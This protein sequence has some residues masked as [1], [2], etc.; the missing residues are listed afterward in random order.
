L[1]LTLHASGQQ[2][3]LAPGDFTTWLPISD[4]EREMKA[5]IVEKEAGAEVLLWRVHVVDELLGNNSELQRVFYHYIRLK[6]FDEKGKE[7]TSTIDLPYVAPGAILAVSGRTIKADGTV[8]ELDRKSVYRRDVVRAGGSARKAVSFAMPGV[9]RGSIVEYRWKEIENDNRFRYLRLHFQREFP[10]Q[11]VTYF[12]K[13]LPGDVTSGEQMFLRPFN[14]RTS[15][16]KQENDGYTSTT[17]QNVP[18]GREEIFAPSEPNR[19]PWAL[20]FYSAGAQKD[21]DKYWNE[22]GRKAYGDLKSLLK[23][24]DELK[25]ASAEATSGV[26]G[27]EEKISAMVLY[28]RKHLRNLFDPDV[29][30]ADRQKYFKSLPRDRFRSAAEIFKSG[31]AT[32]REMNVVFAAI[33][34]HA[35]LEARPALVADQS[36]I[37]LGPKAMTDTYFLDNVAMAIKLGDSWNVFDVSQR[38][39]TPGMLPWREEGVVALV[40]DPKTPVFITTKA[41]A[42]AASS[43]LRSAKLS[44]SAEGLLS[45]DVEESYSGHRAED[46]RESL[47]SKSQAQ[48]EEWLHDRVVR[49]FADADVTSIQLDNVDDAAK[50]LSV[51]YHLEAPRFA[52]VTGKRLFFQPIAFRRGQASPFSASERRYPVQLPYAWKESDQ[53]RIQLPEGFSLDNADSPAGMDFGKP[54]SYQV[55]ISVVKSNIQ[56]LV[57]SREFTFGDQG[58]VYFEPRVYPTIKKAFDEVQVRDGHSISLKGN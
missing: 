35:G 8:L 15:P 2:K 38:S 29:T 1:L 30:Q 16:L 19:E 3:T 9:E 27:D 6:I 10:V 58:I 18:A 7:K 4:A 50:P 44:L 52:Q 26:A 21:P 51:R 49:M 45:G 28:V 47:L 57:V 34:M 41:A 36:E 33:A 13:P 37:A 39:L 14:C 42:P 54:G 31:I 53:I 24:N 22:Q 43:E 40:T 11:S 55:K 32:P 12:V 23:S 46:Y 56:E 20:L 17:V 25:T 48:R 5:P